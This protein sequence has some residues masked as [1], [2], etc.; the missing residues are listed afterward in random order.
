MADDDFDGKFYLFLP[1]AVAQATAAKCGLPEG[2]ST[3]ICHI[4]CEKLRSPIGRQ[5][6]GAERSRRLGEA[7]E[8]DEP[9]A[10]KVEGFLT[11][12]RGRAVWHG[13]RCRLPCGLGEGQS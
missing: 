13:P 7:R 9:P 4:L 11:H 2:W 3:E 5:G 12:L 8:A 6:D 1:F 10:V